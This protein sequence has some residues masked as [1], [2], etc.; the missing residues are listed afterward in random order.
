MS[1]SEI[2]TERNDEGQVKKRKEEIQQSKQK[3]P[4]RYK[5]PKRDATKRKEWMGGMRRKWEGE[6][7]RPY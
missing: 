2:E 5:Q 4:A 6:G 7:I 3:H 1:G